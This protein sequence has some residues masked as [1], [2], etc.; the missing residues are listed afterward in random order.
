MKYHLSICLFYLTLM[1]GGRAQLFLTDPRNNL[2]F[3]INLA[4]VSDLFSTP[5]LSNP[6]EQ[7]SSF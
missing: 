4:F 6:K 3:G 5:S 2:T 7:P 1:L